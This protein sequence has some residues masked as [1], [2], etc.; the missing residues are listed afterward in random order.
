MSTLVVV[1]QPENWN[2]HIP[3]ISV[4]SARSYLVDPQFINQSHTQ[5]FNLC[6]SY[7]YQS[8][9]YYVSLLAEA[10]GHR[11]IPNIST[12]QDMKLST[13]VKLASE[14]LDDLI[15]TS[16]SPLR[17]KE[18]VLSIYFGHNV[19]KR[20]DRL[21]NH[22]FKLFEVPFL[23]AN[24]VKTAQGKWQLQNISPIATKD[25]PEEH[26][27]KVIRFITE[28]FSGK[29]FHVRKKQPPRYDLAIL[30]NPEETH[31]PSNERALKA[32]I[33]AADA[34]RLGAELVT[35]DDFARLGEFDAL[36][37]RETTNVHHHTFRFAR[38]AVAEGLI[39][40]DDPGSILR[41]TNKVY[42]AELLQRNKVPVPKT[43]IVHKQNIHEV[44]P[45]IQLPCILKQ[46]DSAFSQGVSKAKTEEEF[47]YKA[48]QLLEK[49]ELVVAQEYMPTDFDWR[50]GIFDQKPL[51]AC[52]YYMASKHWQIIKTEKNGK[53]VEGNFKTI[54]IELAPPKVV[55]TA[56]KAANLIGD[57]LYGVDLKQVGNEVYVIEV[58]DNPNI[59]GGIEDSVLKEHLYLQIME[60]FARRLEQRKSRWS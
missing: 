18:F 11:P 37:I 58:N 42:L 35:K 52:K 3:D 59:D 10:R 49:S 40:V 25:I 13:L 57:G 30:Y 12:I 60:V 56:L 23:R 43:M 44:I 31:P 20:Y 4:V 7:R 54:P 55:K 17:S 27:S 2:L 26:R 33:K 1:D 6:R 5:I 48:K 34:L 47:I 14:E 8:L 22:L 41:C 53:F 16:L 45:Q 39:V 51:Y 29:R 38:K 19:A 28:Y 9:G 21:C 36:F 46:P 50:I 24:F 32:F 15:Q